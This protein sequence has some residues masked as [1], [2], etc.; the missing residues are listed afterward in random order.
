MVASPAPTPD[1]RAEEIFARTRAA[2]VARQYPPTIAYSVR[3]SGFR[4]GEWTG[5]SYAAFEHWPSASV[6]ARSVSD[7]ETADPAKP[8]GFN[9]GFFGFAT[10]KAE[11]HDVLGIPKLAPTYA[12]GLA[13]PSPL[14]SEDSAAG[15]GALRTII[16]ISATARTYRIRLF[17]EESV[18][19]DICWHLLLRPVGNPGKYR[20]RDLWVD[21]K[22]YETVRLRTNGNF[23]GTET[24]SGLWTVAYTQID[25]SWYLT[26]E[27]S[28]G[29]VATDDG[30]YDHVAVQFTNIRADPREVL[31]FGLE[32]A[33]DQP[34]LI[35]P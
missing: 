31:D 11:S 17:R 28:N 20:L 12:F 26:S 5:R 19:G 18:D 33:S 32:G 1:A 25:G 7:E 9:I 23:T 27:V 4:A 29:P 6:V 3:V 14:R 13:G 16:S 22:S 8:R 15:A 10:S 2:F 24:G 34:D 30:A 21:E 35:E